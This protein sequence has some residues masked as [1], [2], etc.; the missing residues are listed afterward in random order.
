M[1]GLRITNYWIVYFLFNFLLCLITSLIFFLLGALVV[2]TTFFTDT[3]KLLLLLIMV[4]WSLA[5]IGLA[6]FFQTFLSKARS[7]NIIGY[8]VAIWTMMI[9][10]TL[11]IGLYQF[12]S[13]FPLILQM[14][15]PF[16][17]NRLFYLML[18]ECSDYYCYQS[19]S[20]ITQEMQQCIAFL[21]IGF[22]FFFFLGA[23]LF[24]ILP[25]E[26][27]VKR[28]PFFPFVWLY[29]LVTCRSRAI[30]TLTTHRDEALRDY[31][32]EDEEDAFSK[33]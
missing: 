17:F 7:A 5:Q 22:I 25:Q 1:N 18:I 8:L 32:A 33:S 11:N 26:L 15:P 6:A 28:S 24:E 3:S 13:H 27:G 4:G 12:P 31:I 16:A 21:Y 14:L 2:R 19:L 9:G 29:K 23:Y 10:S 20:S 30:S